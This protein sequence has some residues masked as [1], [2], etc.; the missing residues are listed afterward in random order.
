MINAKYIYVRIGLTSST[1]K[2]PGGTEPQ[3]GICPGRVGVSRLDRPRSDAVRNADAVRNVDV[4][5]IVDVAVR[6]VDAAR[7]VDVAGIADAARNV[8]I[9]RKTFE[10]PLVSAVV[11][12]NEN[13]V[14]AMCPGR[15]SDRDRDNLTRSQTRQVTLEACAGHFCVT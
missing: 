4:A 2:I 14:M 6:N 13:Q 5:G 7:N 9:V 10:A 8:V 3:A 11:R 15:P 12:E 1:G